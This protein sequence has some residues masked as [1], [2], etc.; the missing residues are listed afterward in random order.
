MS[1]PVRI[2]ATAA[3]LRIIK[4]AS[5]EA[6]RVRVGAILRVVETGGGGGGGG[7]TDLSIAN[8]TAGGLDIAS[9]TGADAALPAATDTLAGLMTAAD[10]A[11]LNGV[12]AG[13]TAN[14]ADAALRDRA[15]HTGTQAI[16]TVSGLQ[17]ALDGKQASLGF[18]PE[19]AASK[20]QAGGYAALDGTGRVPSAQLPSFVDDVIEVA[21]FAALPG[22]GETGKIYVTLSDGRTL[23]W[24]GSAYVE[25]S[26]SPGS[27]DA[28]PEG[29]GN[30]YHTAARVLG[31]VLTGLSTATASAV[32]ATDSILAAIGKL[33][34]QISDAVASIGAKENAGVAASAVA[35]HEAAVDPHPQ[36]LTSAEGAAAYAPLASAVPNGGNTGQVLAKTSNA[37]QATAWVTPSGGGGS[38]DPL[39]LTATNPAVPP[40]DTVRLFRRKIAGRNLPA[41]IGP[42]GLDSAFQSAFHSNRV[43]LIS[44]ASNIAAATVLGMSLTAIGTATNA[45]SFSVNLHQSM[46]R[47]EYLVTAAA[48]TAIAGVRGAAVTTWR[49]NAAKRGGFFF[50]MR[51]GPATGA[52]TLTTRAFVG[53]GPLGAPTDVEPSSRLNIIGMGWDAA[54]ANIQ[55]MHND[56]TGAATKIDLGASFP[57]SVADR[58]DIYEIVMFCP[59]NGSS[60]FWQVTDLN[61][62][63]TA[64]GEITTDLPA[65][66][67]F[68]A[69]LGAISVGGTSSVIGFALF[70]FYLESDY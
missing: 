58:T 9:S 64:T 40:A 7:A 10:K 59:P 26:A 62:D 56:G 6:L 49:G 70:Q 31:V 43:A 17:G 63:A 45:G 46:A 35:A 11:K 5:S 48:A 47:T 28:V 38:V 13:A 65:A 21:N 18:T 20:G 44:P 53:L 14:A 42:S 39:D 57:V 52:T 32:Q 54:D 19:N 15:T 33:Q 66:T 68:L 23:R 1:D 29:A 51:W 30:L 55:M 24:S 2:L 16:A 69:L 25:I 50:R 37:D 36:Y 61:T 4:A 34:R 60:V 12:A 8:R 27:T 67:Q 3:Q 22:G 41:F